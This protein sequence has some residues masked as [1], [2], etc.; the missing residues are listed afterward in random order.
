MSMAISYQPQVGNFL[1]MTS[2]DTAYVTIIPFR[3]F[4]NNAVLAKIFLQLWLSQVLLRDLLQFNDKTIELIALR[5]YFHRIEIN[6]DMQLD[7]SGLSM[8]GP[9]FMHTTDGIVGNQD[10]ILQLINVLI[11]FSPVLR[12]RLS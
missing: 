11:R 1:S 5:G 2:P 7:I 6:I 8:P 10:G 3:E 9:Q 4:A 12:Q